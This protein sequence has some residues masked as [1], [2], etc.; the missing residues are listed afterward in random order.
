MLNKTSESA[1]AKK[2]SGNADGE[3]LTLRLST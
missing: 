3:N 2:W 1:H